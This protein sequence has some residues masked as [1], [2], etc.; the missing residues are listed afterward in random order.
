MSFEPQHDRG[1][2][3]YSSGMFRRPHH[4]PDEPENVLYVHLTRDGAIFVVGGNG[5]QA[6]ITQRQLHEELRALK[7]VSG[8]LLYS[9][10][11]PAGELS[12]IAFETFKGISEHQLPVKLVDQPHPDVANPLPDRGTYLMVF[13][14]RGEDELV[15]DLLARGADPD[16]HDANGYTAL[17]HAANLGHD[18]CVRLLLAHGANPNT[19]ENEGSTPLLFAAQHGHTRVV[20]RLLDAG[21]APNA[22]GEGGFTPLGIALRNNRTTTA[23]VLLLAGGRE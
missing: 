18:G 20:K 9:R 19:T 15:E 2:L 4:N 12:P 22:R 23:S 14:L 5:T 16:T 17:M 6:W 1:D 21:A 3:D 10:D 7:S 8:T 11:D 13:A